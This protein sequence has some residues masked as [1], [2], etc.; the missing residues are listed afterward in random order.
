MKA[1]WSDRI[2]VA[3][4]VYLEPVLITGCRHRAGK[5]DERTVSRWGR[6]A[7][8]RRLLDEGFPLREVA[9]RLMARRDRE[10]QRAMTPLN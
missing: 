8:I 5:G 10:L 1:I 9:P 7:I 6:E 3:H 2:R 4:K